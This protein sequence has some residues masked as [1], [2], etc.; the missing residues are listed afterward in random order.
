M[1]TVDEKSIFAKWVEDNCFIDWEG[2]SFD[3]MQKES[4]SMAD[5]LEK[6]F[7]TL[8][9]KVRADERQKVLGL[10]IELAGDVYEGSDWKTG[11]Q[12]LVDELRTKLNQLKEAK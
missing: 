7:T 3:E 10:A 2:D 9:T 12:S 4:K 5:E 1:R 11:R 8:E 6:M